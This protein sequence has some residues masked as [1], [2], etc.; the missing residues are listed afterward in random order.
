MI[1]LTQ[2]PLPHLRRGLDYHAQ[3]ARP[4]AE[5][6]IATCVLTNAKG[7]LLSARG[8]AN[9]LFIRLDDGR[10]LHFRWWPKKKVVAVQRSYWRSSLI[11][12]ASTADEMR[13][14]MEWF[15]AGKSVV[16][17]AAA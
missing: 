13:N 14:L 10:E 16:Y 8:K 2:A 1:D 6:G 12:T 3:A 11:A 15:F 17:K 4:M 9:S 5:A 7:V